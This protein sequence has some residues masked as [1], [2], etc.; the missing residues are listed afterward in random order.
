MAIFAA[1]LVLA[2]FAHG[3]ATQ[4]PTLVAALGS[5][6]PETVVVQITV[7][8]ERKGEFFVKVIDGAFLAR[9]KDLTTIGLIGAQGRTWAPGGSDEYVWVNS[10]PG[11]Q[12]TFDE[13]RL[14]LDLTADPKLLPV[15][16]VD[17]W[18]GRGEKV[19]YPDNP[20]RSSTT[21]SA[22]RRKSGYG[23]VSSA[24]RRSARGMAISSF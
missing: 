10:I 8:R 6:G 7:N 15:T 2:A 11:I 21:T 9:A 24:R 22:M 20:A 3:A 13:A 23:M 17:L 19:V 5:A 4:E 12:A 16:T 18:S 1:S 14:S